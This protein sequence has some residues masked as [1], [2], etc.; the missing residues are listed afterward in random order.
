MFVSRDTKY[1]QYGKQ[2]DVL[3]FMSYDDT[4]KMIEYKCHFTIINTNYEVRE[5]QFCYW[6]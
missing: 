2:N 3:F 6:W 4:I 5:K 1:T